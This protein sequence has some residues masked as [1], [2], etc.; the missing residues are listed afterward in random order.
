[1]FGS[2]LLGVPPAILLFVGLLGMGDK[3]AFAN[4]GFSRD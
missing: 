1:L 4:A 3:G 2:I